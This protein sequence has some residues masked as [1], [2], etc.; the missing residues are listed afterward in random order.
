MEWL[1]KLIRNAPKTESGEIDVEAL[2][3]QASKELPKYAVPKEVYNAAKKERDEAKTAL[4]EAEKVDV[5]ALQFQFTHPYGVRLVWFD[6][7]R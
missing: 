5:A 1:R 2:V 3:E 4:A 6:C 7:E